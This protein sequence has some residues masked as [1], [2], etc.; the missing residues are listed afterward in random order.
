MRF[1]KMDQEFMEYYSTFSVN[2]NRC[3]LDLIMETADSAL[4]DPKNHLKVA[5]LLLSPVIRIGWGCFRNICSS[6]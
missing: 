1:F 4:E 3:D 2:Y 6:K 5:T